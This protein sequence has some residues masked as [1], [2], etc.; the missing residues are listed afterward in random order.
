MDDS[1][2]QIV[3]PPAEGQAFFIGGIVIPEVQLD[4][5][6][7]AWRAATKNFE[8]VE[9]GKRPRTPNDIKAVDFLHNYHMDGLDASRREAPA[10]SIV[11]QLAEKFDILPLVL[12]IPKAEAGDGILGKTKKGG[13]TIRVSET[14]PMLIG[15]F[16]AFLQR[17]SAYGA[18]RMDRL[19]NTT[20]E[21][22]FKRLWDVHVKGV[23][24]VSKELEFVGSESY[25]E[26]QLAD[27]L[28]GLLRGV[29]ERDGEIP[30][31]FVDLIRRAQAS[32]LWF[33]QLT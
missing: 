25:P 15:T 1:G 14:L 33:M 5:F 27:V 21:I 18:V 22:E 2:M 32:S 30:R 12:A 8:L 31:A 13:S 24:R 19:K 11:A 6:R 9:S 3:R 20:E 28:L 4:A 7:G 10:L 17:K 29:F 16:G 26:V 23:R